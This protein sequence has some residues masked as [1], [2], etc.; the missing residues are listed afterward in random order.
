MQAIF[1]QLVE[2]QQFEFQNTTLSEAVEPSPDNGASRVESGAPDRVGKATGA[3]VTKSVETVT[4][5]PIDDVEGAT[6][7]PE[8]DS[9]GVEEVEEATRG[10]EDEDVE[11]EDVE[12]ATRGPEDDVGVEDVEEATRVPEDG[13]VEDAKRSPGDKDME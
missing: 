7:G 8:D 5:E 6:G 1:S 11:V 13:D 4:H 3:P 2:F 10:P 12:G 9:V